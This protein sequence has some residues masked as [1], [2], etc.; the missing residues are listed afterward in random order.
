MIMRQDHFVYRP[1]STKVGKMIAMFLAGRLLGP[2]WSRY[3]VHQYS[4]KNNA[5][6]GTSRIQLQSQHATGPQESLPYLKVMEPGGNIQLAQTIRLEFW[7]N[8]EKIWARQFPWADFDMAEVVDI[9]IW[10]RLCGKDGK[11]CGAEEG[12]HPDNRVKL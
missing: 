1:D 2:D 9:W 6:D 5:F 10:L 4:E 3:A 7:S 11:L 12:I 8:G